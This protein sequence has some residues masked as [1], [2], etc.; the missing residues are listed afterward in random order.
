[1]SEIKNNEIP[2]KKIVA[3]SLNQSNYA[4]SLSGTFDNIDKNFA[5]LANYDFIKGESGE[6]IRI[7]E[8]S[9]FNEDGELNEYGKK[10]HKY[11][12]DNFSEDITKDITVNG[13]TISLFE[14]FTPEK[15]GNLFLI[16]T[17]YND[18][19][20]TS[21][22]VASLYYVFL[23]G[24]FSN[25]KFAKDKVE[26]EIYNDIEDLSCILIYDKD[27]AEFK[28]LN[29]AFPTIYYEK[30]VGLCWKVNGNET[31]MPVKGQRGD[32]GKD[33]MLYFVKC[34]RTESDEDIYVKSKV[35]G[36][37]NYPVTIPI[38]D[39]SDND[40][41]ELNNCS[42][43]ILLEDGTKNYMYFGQLMYEDEEVFAY[44]YDN[45]ELTYNMQTADF[46]NVLKGINITSP[47]FNPLRGLFIPMEVE[48][49][50]TT[51]SAHFAGAT[52]ITN[53]TGDQ[54]DGKRTDLILTPINDINDFDVTSDPG[55]KLSVEKYLYVK[56]QEDGFEFLGKAFTLNSL[57]NLSEIQNVVNDLVRNK[58][59]LKYKLINVCKKDDL[60]NYTWYGKIS[61]NGTVDLNDKNKEF[62][63]S[64]IENSIASDPMRTIPSEF[65]NADLYCWELCD[66]SDNDEFKTN[67][68]T[69]LSYT[70]IT[71]K[72]FKNIFTNTINPGLSTN[73]LWY[74]GVELHEEYCNLEAHKYRMFGWGIGYHSVIPMSF[75]KFV[76]LFKNDFSYNGDTTLNINYNINVTGNSDEKHAKR[77]LNINGD[78][79]CDNA[80]ILKTAEIGEIKDVYTQNDIV[81][82]SGIKIGKR[83]S[84]KYNTVIDKNGN[85]NLSNTLNTNAVTAKSIS[86]TDVDAKN[87][88]AKNI[89][90]STNSKELFNINIKSNQVTMTNDTPSQDGNIQDD[91]PGQYARGASTGASTTESGENSN[92][93]SWKNVLNIIGDDI[94]SINLN[95]A[96]INSAIENDLLLYNTNKSKIVFSNS[97][98]LDINDDVY[99]KTSN[100]IFHTLTDKF[101]NYSER[102]PVVLNGSLNYPSLISSNALRSNIG[103][104]LPPNN[105]SYSNKQYTI[106]NSNIKSSFKIEEFDLTNSDTSRTLYNSNIKLNFGYYMFYVMC[107]ANGA[108]KDDNFV[109][110]NH[111][112]S[113][114]KLSIMLNAGN[115]QVELSTQTLKFNAQHCEDRFIG[116]DQNGNKIT[117]I[118]D[119]L[120]RYQAYVFKPSSIVISGANLNRI[121]DS[122]DYRQTVEITV[123][124]EIKIKFYNNGWDGH[125]KH[126]LCSNII[127]LHVEKLYNSSGVETSISNGILQEMYDFVAET[128]NNRKYYFNS[129]KQS[130]AL[131]WN[132]N[133]T[134]SHS[135]INYICLKQRSSS[136]SNTTVCCEDGII[137]KAGTA[138]VGLGLISDNKNDTAKE[139]SLAFYDNDISNADEKLKHITISKLFT[140]LLNN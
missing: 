22:P 59:I 124:P 105:N 33:A 130:H 120:Q 98:D 40:K 111:D 13:V 25:G 139:L 35:V 20:D 46:I 87:I 86:S 117:N 135:N 113:Y 7:E 109:R 76:P 102:V 94:K 1:M 49:E 70:S 11:F 24:R 115:T 55:E 28:S 123:I 80:F 85:M 132:S 45:M 92:Y 82:D 44:Y 89:G 66:G 67:V 37:Y 31:G 136:D 60:A 107:D 126:A 77:N 23:D 58:Y 129:N 48:N 114:V 112:E 12:D 5:T 91:I 41:Q 73:F 78:S 116:V 69:N 18:V 84:S 121:K 38:E 39:L 61:N 125:I 133:I 47:D 72:Y 93:S 88:N 83:Q 71:K 65:E 68:N 3:P 99:A 57:Y 79:S 56:V 34:E 30:N 110:I 9:F 95:R 8:V 104:L 42:S 14:N 131:S 100:D 50:D 52:S 2:L 16:T 74:N 106:D 53:Q 36:I 17:T 4:E 137:I 118:K 101:D 103:V 6:S 43:L 64:Y 128:S 75:A 19:D 21:I 54:L 26:E 63:L 96:D 122:F 138:V 10:I 81:T 134:K 29:N 127:P 90:V 32:D 97:N 51:Q 62:S 108:I 15:A 27:T 140:K 119:K